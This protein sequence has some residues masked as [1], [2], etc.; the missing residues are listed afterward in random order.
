MFKT[1]LLSGI[2]LLLALLGM[3]LLG[4]EVLLFSLTVIALIGLFEFYRIFQIE[5]SMIGLAGYLITLFYFLNIGWK[6]IEDQQLFI[7]GCLALFLTIFVLA[8]PK[9]KANQIFAAMFGIIYVG[10]MISAVY[11]TRMLPFGVYLVWLIFV[12]SWG[13]DTCAYCVGVLFGKHKLAPV[14][15]PKKS[16]EGAIGGIA[17]ASLIALIYGIVLWKLNLI[18]LSTIGIWILIAAIGSVFSQIG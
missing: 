15:S 2:V 7:V 9:Y 13:S 18:Q 10:V 3:L 12:C 17:G 14:L 8:Y 5:K 16:I 4:G 1:R 11:H 6:V